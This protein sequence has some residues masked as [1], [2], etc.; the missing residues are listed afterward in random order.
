MDD[1][2]I[3]AFTASAP[4]DKLSALLVDLLNAPVQTF[5]TLCLVLPNLT[6]RLS[7]ALLIPDEEPV[8]PLLTALEEGLLR[9]DLDPGS[10]TFVASGLPHTDERRLTW[11]LGRLTSVLV[12]ARQQPVWTFSGAVRSL[13]QPGTP[14]A[15]VLQ[16]LATQDSIT[17]KQLLARLKT[18]DPELGWSGPLLRPLLLA[19]VRA[20][21][22]QTETTG[23]SLLY[24]LGPVGTRLITE[25]SNRLSKLEAAYRAYRLGQNAPTTPH[26]LELLAIFAR[27]DAEKY[28]QG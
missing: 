21:L 15:R 6:M 24:R 17:Q 1:E 23:S 13:V 19:L 26:T 4:P 5:S 14:G 27:V 7:R 8:L 25:Q 12:L 16:A 10:E 2:Q 18:Q 22:L 3:T 20:E 28:P 9:F 11:L